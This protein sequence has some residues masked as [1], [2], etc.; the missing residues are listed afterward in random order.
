MGNVCFHIMKYLGNFRFAHA[1]QHILPLLRVTS[2][3]E[4]LIQLNLDYLLSSVE[5]YE[6]TEYEIAKFSSIIIRK[7][8]LK[9]RRTFHEVCLSECKM[10]DRRLHFVYIS[11]DHMAVL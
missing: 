1:S 6:I 10:C 5:E 8:T 2:A 4:E 9:T 11:R 3:K 7:K